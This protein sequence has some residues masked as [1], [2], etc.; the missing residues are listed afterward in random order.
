[1]ITAADQEEKKALERHKKKREAILAKYE[2]QDGVLDRPDLE[3]EL[4][5]ETQR[6]LKEL[7]EIRKNGN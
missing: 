7:Q 1:M 2:R 5:D 4:H 6:F 3:K